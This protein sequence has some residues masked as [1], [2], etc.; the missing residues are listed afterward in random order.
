MADGV[1]YYECH[2]P[3]FRVYQW[4]RH[5]STLRV[6]AHGSSRWRIVKRVP[7]GDVPTVAFIL[8]RDRRTKTRG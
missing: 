3:S 7:V 1:R 4:D 5:A 6:R 8:E 2:A